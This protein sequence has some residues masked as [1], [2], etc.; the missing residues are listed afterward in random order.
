M[1]LAKIRYKIYNDKFLTTIKVFKTWMYYLKSYKYKFLIF[2]DYNNLYY[3]INTKNYA[4]IKFV[5]SKSFFITIFKLII[6]KL[7]LITL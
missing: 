1:I 5:G 2:I 4:F 6:I 7:K 3:F